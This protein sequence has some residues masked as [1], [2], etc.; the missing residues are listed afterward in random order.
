MVPDWNKHDNLFKLFFELME[1]VSYDP[2]YWLW[3]LNIVAVQCG[4][5]VFMCNLRLIFLF[6]HEIPQQKKKSKK[7]LF[8]NIFLKH[9][10]YIHKTITQYHSKPQSSTHTHYTDCLG[11]RL[12]R[13]SKPVFATERWD[14]SDHMKREKKTE[15]ELIEETSGKP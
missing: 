2:H 6:H 3:L 13:M 8:S 5:P 4:L 10:P 7:N 11:P 12:P 15:W 14:P 9:S 1:P